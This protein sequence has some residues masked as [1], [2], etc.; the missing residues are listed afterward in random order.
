VAIGFNS[1]N[2]FQ[3][4]LNSVKENLT[5]EEVNKLLLAKENE[6]SAVFHMA[7]GFNSLDKFQGILNFFKKI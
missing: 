5:T 6:G 2:V 7:I 1:I 3:R 4:T